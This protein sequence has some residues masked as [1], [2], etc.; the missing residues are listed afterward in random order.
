MDKHMFLYT[1]YQYIVE[2]IKKNNII[3]VFNTILVL[4][5]I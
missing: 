4:I 5:L 2:F 3:F 1:R